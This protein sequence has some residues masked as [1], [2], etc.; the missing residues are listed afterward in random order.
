MVYLNPRPRPCELET[1]YPKSYVPYRFDEHL[2][3][4]VNSLRMASQGFKVKALRKFAGQGA[5]IWDVGC[6]GGFFMEC[7]KKYGR[8]SWKLTAVDISESA[9]EKVKMK[10]FEGICGRFETLTIEDESVDAVVLNQVI[11][12]LD[13]PAAV[14]E[15]AWCLLKPNGIIFIETPSLEGWDAELFAS[16]YWGGWHFPRHWTFFT[17]RML[18]Q[19]LSQKNFAVVEINWLLSPIFWI[20]SIHHWLVD[21]GLPKR[22]AR[23]VDCKN[24]VL[25]AVFCSVDLVQKLFGHTSNMRVV[26]KKVK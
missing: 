12:H 7:L 1:I 21:K 6:G 10:G 18:S 16:R 2:S 20:Q 24:P 26:A 19:L 17:S 15:K 9:I 14:I 23:W 8:D 22:Y 3:R 5:S 25:L 11:E 13:D 4:F